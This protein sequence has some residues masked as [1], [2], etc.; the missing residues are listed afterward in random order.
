M[1]IEQSEG[2]M[3]KLGPKLGEQGLETETTTRGASLPGPHHN[4]DPNRVLPYTPLKIKLNPFCMF[5]M[6]FLYVIPCL[7]I[8]CSVAQLTC[9]FPKTTAYNILPS[10][11]RIYFTPDSKIHFQYFTHTLALYSTASFFP[12]SLPF[13]SF[14]SFHHKPFEQTFQ[15]LQ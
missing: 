4:L 11:Y 7:H 14:L 8:P 2:N 6:I 15:P 3:E 13:S 10:F 12:P 9:C 1:G 5:F